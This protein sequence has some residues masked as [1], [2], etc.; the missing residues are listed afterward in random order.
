MNCTW[1]MRNTTSGL[2][3]AFVISIDCLKDVNSAL[4]SY[5]P[6]SFFKGDRLTEMKN[7]RKLENTMSKSCV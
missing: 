3:W 7:K 5:G 1:F 2:Y 6:E 4:R